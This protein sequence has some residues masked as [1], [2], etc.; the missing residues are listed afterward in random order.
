MRSNSA[1]SISA[2]DGRQRPLQ[3]IE[4]RAR[5]KRRDGVDEIGDGFRL[6]QI[7]P[8]VEKRAQRELA[9]LGEPRAARHGRGDDRAQ[10]DRASV[11]AQ[12]DDVLAGVRMRRRESR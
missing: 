10:N 12:L 3:L 1:A 6:R 7:D 11:R 8:A 2:I 9:R 4:R 5:L